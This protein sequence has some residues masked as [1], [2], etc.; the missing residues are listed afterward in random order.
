M[1]GIA[2][3]LVEMNA[4]LDDST[5]YGGLRTRKRGPLDDISVNIEP[6]Q[7]W[8][9]SKSQLSVA[10]S[11]GL[12][13][14]N[15]LLNNGVEISVY[16]RDAADSKREGY[17]IRIGDEA[18]IGFDA[19]LTDESHPPSMRKVRPIFR[20]RERGTHDLQP[21]IREALLNLTKLSRLL[22]IGGNQPCCFEEHP[23]EAYTSG[24]TCPMRKKKVEQIRHCH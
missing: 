2:P 14:A 23:A 21:P 17:Q 20:G 12:P 6:G 5:Y 16:E 4:G 10:V 9:I 19:C 3:Q 8:R 13:L 15:G 1:R 24:W 18:D 11:L 7:P 22:Q